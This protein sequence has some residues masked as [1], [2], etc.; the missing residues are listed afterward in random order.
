MWQDLL[1]ARD[2]VF[3]FDHSSS[4]LPRAHISRKRYQILICRG[5][6]FHALR[7]YQQPLK[8]AISMKP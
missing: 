3:G 1:E 6:G 7:L 2:S 5:G 4:K 8:M